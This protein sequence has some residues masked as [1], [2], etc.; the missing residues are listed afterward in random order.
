MSGAL[1]TFLLS[2]L[3]DKVFTRSKCQRVS[4]I[5]MFAAIVPLLVIL[6]CSE[7]N[8]LTQ[9]ILV[10]CIIL[11]GSMAAPYLSFGYEI[12]TNAAYP[13]SENIPIT[14]SIMISYFISA[15]GVLLL[16]KINPKEYRIKL[17]LILAVVMYFL[18]GVLTLFVKVK[19]KSTHN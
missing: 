2:L 3:L 9:C 11:Y 5:I 10:I 14:I 15:I 13:I 7:M 18:M 16:D 19:V 4:W 1:F 17:S 8:K 6:I 12:M